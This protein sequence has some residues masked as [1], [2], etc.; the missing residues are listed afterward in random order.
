MS[1]YLC[2][3]FYFIWKRMFKRYMINVLVYR[4]MSLSEAKEAAACEI[5]SYS[6]KDEYWKYIHP[7]D[8]AQEALSYWSD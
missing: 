3:H 6:R 7:H 1:D 5:E 2:H 4:G 8:A